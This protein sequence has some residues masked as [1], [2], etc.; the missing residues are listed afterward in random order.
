MKVIRSKPYLPEGKKN[1]YFAHLLPIHILKE[2]PPSVPSFVSATF[3]S[4]FTHTLP[5]LKYHS[6]SREKIRL[7]LK[8]LDSLL[9]KLMLIELLSK[10]CVLL[11]FLILQDFHPFHSHKRR[12]GGLPRK[13]DFNSLLEFC[14]SRIRSQESE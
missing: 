3:H 14:F 11:C 7:C 12:G 2:A 4:I 10:F 13:P 9:T 8:M 5:P 6:I 1:L